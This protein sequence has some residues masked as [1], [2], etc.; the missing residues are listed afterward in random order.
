METPYVVTYGLPIAVSKVWQEMFQRPSTMSGR[1]HQ[2]AFRF[3]NDGTEVSAVL[4]NEPAPELMLVLQEYA[5]RANA[6]W[7]P[8]RK[9]ILANRE[10]EARILKRL[11]ES[12]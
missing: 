3:N 11:Q 6:R 12:T 2:I 5:K 7:E 1:V 10:E 8:Y 9:K 4:P